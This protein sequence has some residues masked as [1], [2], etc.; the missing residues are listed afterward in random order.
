MGPTT[1]QWTAAVSGLA[2]ATTYRYA[3]VAIDGE[4]RSPL[5][6]EVVFTTL[7][8]TFDMLAPTD[9]VA[10][11]TAE[12]WTLTWTALDEATA[13][14]VETFALQLVAPDV[15]TLDFTGGITALPAGWTTTSTQ[16]SGVAG[17]FGAA[18][19]SLMLQAGE[20][21]QSPAFEAPIV[22]Y[23]F[24]AKGDVTATLIAADRQ[25]RLTNEGEDVAYLDDV[26]VSYGGRAEHID[27][28]MRSTADKSAAAG[29]ASE[30]TL[31]IPATMGQRYARVRGV[32][33][34]GLRSEWS[35]E[36]ALPLLEGIG[37]VLADGLHRTTTR[38]DL[39]GRRV[40]G[41]PSGVTIGTDG[42][43]ATR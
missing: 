37:S 26:T 39:H 32:R 21:L 10:V 27:S 36:V 15:V 33:A 12:G 22:D 11:P 17:T 18:R 6:N 16:T 38:Y 4:R 42:R 2:P 19:P 3:V 14:E 24:W 23:T 31:I 20:W 41:S 34:D 29:S 35:A 40:S 28:E 9:L 25:L 5:S 7:P 1:E 8:P 30:P 13:Y 43:K